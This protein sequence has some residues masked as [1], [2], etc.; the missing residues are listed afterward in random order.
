MANINTELEQIRKAVYGREV[1]GS[2]ANAIELINKEQINTSTA[3]TSLDSKFEQLIINAGNSNAEVVAARVKADG[4]QFNTL[5]K[6]LDKSD[7]VHKALN[8]E[9]ISARTD[10]KNVA[11]K[12][13]KA[14]LDNFD[15][16]LDTKAKKRQIYYLSDYGKMNDATYDNTP[17]FKQAIK[18]LQKTGG[19]LIIDVGSWEFKTPCVIDE[20]LFGCEIVG[21]S[22][23]ITNNTSDI[24]AIRGNFGTIL[25]YSGSGCMFTFNGKMNHCRIE[26]LYALLPD[27]TEFMKFNYTFHKGIIKD[28]SVLGGK[29]C[30]DFNTGTYVRIENF[31]YGSS[32]KNAEYGIRIG[33]SETRYTTEF[34]Y[35]NNS[36]IDFGNLSNAN[37]IDIYRLEGGFYID[38]TDLCNTNGVGLRVENM[39]G[40][41]INYFVIRDVNFTRAFIGV[42]LYAKT[43]NIGGVFIDNVRYG[44]KCSSKDERIVKCYAESGKTVMIHHK[45]AYVRT[46]SSLIPT[47]VAELS[48]MD[49]QS[50]FE[51]NAGNTLAGGFN[52]PI[53]LGSDISKIYDY[54]IE[55]KGTKT[56]TLSSLTPSSVGSSWKDYK[57]E[58]VSLYPYFYTT[59]IVLVNF[60]Y[61][62]VNGVIKTEIV[63]GILYVYVRIG[64]DVPS[65]NIRM[66]YQILN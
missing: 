5:G 55:Y 38:K 27:K 43:G 31:G 22:R 17:A 61:A 64:N 29:G 4:T 21:M 33:K 23:G 62:F 39:L 28:I 57:I 36:S 52:S 16:Q 19:R 30:L 58:L 24:N 60:N 10:S 56:I 59:P 47:Y 66:N 14:R 32:D 12:N 54:R 53:K 34:F 44:L 20:W 6:R 41:S 18:D 11:H 3:Q 25:N 45:N 35:I 46:Y 8:N 51:I 37:C 2:I 48:R 49:W 65:D 26:N 9:V 1:R 50:V 42:E 40:S 63:D 13:L 7:E 15:S